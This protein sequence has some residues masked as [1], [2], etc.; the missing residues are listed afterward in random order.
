M[1]LESAFAACLLGSRE[2]RF[3]LRSPNVLRLLGDEDD[4]VRELDALRDKPFE[5]SWDPRSVRRF[6]PRL[7]NPFAASPLSVRQES[8]LSERRRGVE[9]VVG[10]AACSIKYASPRRAYQY[11]DSLMGRA[12]RCRSG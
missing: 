11:A 1:A 10:S 2:G 4:F 9:L 8:E 6:S 7:D 3:R 5:P 12:T